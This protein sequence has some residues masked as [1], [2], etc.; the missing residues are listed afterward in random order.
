[1]FI[2]HTARN[3]SAVSN[4]EI[5]IVGQVR[6]V[7]PVRVIGQ[8]RGWVGVALCDWATPLCERADDEIF[9]KGSGCF[10]RP[11]IRRHA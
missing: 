9:A 5:I 6:V 11:S 4:I 7:G 2:T 1:L 8:V 10:L 3:V